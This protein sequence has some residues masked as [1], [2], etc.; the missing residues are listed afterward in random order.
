[1]LRGRCPL[2]G[3][4]ETGRRVG[5]WPDSVQVLGEALSHCGCPPV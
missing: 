3:Y 4:L 2:I 5:V 1:M